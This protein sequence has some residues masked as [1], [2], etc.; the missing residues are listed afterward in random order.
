MGSA[1]CGGLGRFGGLLEAICVDPLKSWQVWI[2]RDS[3]L[4]VSSDN[5]PT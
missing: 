4:G 2:G 3:S 1:K 5:P